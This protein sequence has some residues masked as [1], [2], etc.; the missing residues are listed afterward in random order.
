MIDVSFV[1]MSSADPKF[2][3]FAEFLSGL[4]LMVLAWTIGDVRYRFRIRTA[5]L[6]L[7][8]ITFFGMALLGVLTLMT[9]LWRAQ[10]WSVPVGPLSP[11]LW[12]GLLGVSFLSIFLFWA[13]FAFIWPP[14][15][16]R[17][18]CKRFAQVLYKTILNSSPE[19]LAVVAD[20][21]TR[22]V[23]N[24]IFWGTNKPNRYF[25]NPTPVKKKEVEEFAN[26]ILL[27]IGDPRFCRAIVASSSGT[28]LAVFQD[29]ASSKKYELPVATFAKNIVLEA[30]ENRDSFLFHESTGFDSGLLGYHKPL[31]STIFGNLEM[32]E[33]IKTLL[34]PNGVKMMQWD[35]TQWQAYG[36]VV[37]LALESYATKERLYHTYF[38]SSPKNHLASAVGDIYQLDGVDS[39]K[40]ESEAWRKL[41]AVV[42]FTRDAIE[43][44][45]KYPVP[46]GLRQRMR[47]QDR[48]LETVYDQIAELIF[49]IVFAASAVT[50]PRNTCW[51][52]QHN[53]VWSRLFALCGDGKATKAIHYKFRRLIY[54]EIK[55]MNDLVN[56]KGARI[57]GYCLNVMGVEVHRRGRL[58]SN[59]ALHRIVLAWTKKNYAWLHFK[60]SEVAEACLVAG[61]TYDESNSRLVHT[62]P[63]GGLRRET[64]HYY[65]L[66]D[67][68]IPSQSNVEENGDQDGPF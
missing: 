17:L 67:R 53:S 39:L 35:F 19:E 31:T 4:A 56:F 25:T 27:L 44:L 45:D 6:P 36:R 64:A 58:D 66:V 15:Y 52:I 21:L 14:V 9:D 57:L 38:F 8:G 63:A 13:W 30:I 41:S 65:L 28:A 18:N 37:L 48:Q 20:E 3:G 22:S 46:D 50:S 61:W 34:D 10:E 1:S 16:G 60:N 26:S 43:I 32:V 7:V 2:F 59:I 5:P 62:Y 24:I 49:E 68:Y 42:D 33:N 12:Q 54:D 55:N 51:S 23:E 40:W 11:A 47:A 29:I